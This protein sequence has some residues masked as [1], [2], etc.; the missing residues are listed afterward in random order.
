MSDIRRRLL[1]QM[2][3][4]NEHGE[5]AASI[6]EE[7][8]V[9]QFFKGWMNIIKDNPTPDKLTRDQICEG[10]RELDR[11]EQAKYVENRFHPDTLFTPVSVE[12]NTPTAFNAGDVTF[13][14]VYNDEQTSS[15]QD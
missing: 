2:V 10:L 8:S 6:N 1:P 15:L 14:A 7:S 4:T 9:G 3:F 5:K 13:D 12:C 11:P